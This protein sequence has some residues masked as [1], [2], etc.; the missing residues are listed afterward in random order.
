M[1]VDLH[2][3]NVEFVATRKAHNPADPVNILFKAYHAL[4]L[5]AHVLFPLARYLWWLFCSHG[6]QN[7]ASVWRLPNREGGGGGELTV[8]KLLDSGTPVVV[9]E[10]GLDLDGVACKSGVVGEL[11]VGEGMRGEWMGEGIAAW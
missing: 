2:A 9:L 1:C 11:V 4:H 8:R 3:I 6:C 10:R 7:P 5:F